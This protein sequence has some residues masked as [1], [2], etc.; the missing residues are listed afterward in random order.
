MRG[1]MPFVFALTHLRN[2][3][4]EPWRAAFA[5]ATPS[6][7]NPSELEVALCWPEDIC[8]E[9]VTQLRAHK[10]I[11][12]SVGRW[13]EIDDRHDAAAIDVRN[14][15]NSISVEGIGPGRYVV[16]PIDGFMKPTP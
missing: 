15:Q 3:V 11:P 16:I 10:N 8:K 5:R 14:I 6:K 2:S 4:G 12:R 9:V 13:P 1:T 7:T